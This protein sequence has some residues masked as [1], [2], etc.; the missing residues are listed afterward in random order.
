MDGVSE[1][2]NLSVRILPS[3]IFAPSRVEEKLSKWL[4]VVGR[5]NWENAFTL[6]LQIASVT[7]IISLLISPPVLGFASLQAISSESS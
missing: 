3:P 6:L 5:G 4:S 1:R 7:Q 2:E